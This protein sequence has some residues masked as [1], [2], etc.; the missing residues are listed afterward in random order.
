MCRALFSA[1]TSEAQRTTARSCESSSG[2]VMRKVTP[3]PKTLALTDSPARTGVALFIH[4]AVRL[5]IPRVADLA[6][7]LRDSL[8]SILK[9]FWY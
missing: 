4:R 6:A 3:R 8:L 7:A 9:L 2:R 1:A 5:I